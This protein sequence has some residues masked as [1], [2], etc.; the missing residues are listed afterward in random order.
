[1][2]NEYPDKSI[3]FVR[4]IAEGDLVASMKRGKYVS[5]GM[6]FNKFQRVQRIQ[7]KCIDRESKE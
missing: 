2:Q 5:I 4:C 6:Q 3:E 7:T 1:M